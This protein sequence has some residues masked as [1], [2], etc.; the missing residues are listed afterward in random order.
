MCVCVCV[1]ERERGEFTASC[2]IIMCQREFI[3]VN[4]WHVCPVIIEQSVCV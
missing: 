2:S 3:S 4:V 1:R